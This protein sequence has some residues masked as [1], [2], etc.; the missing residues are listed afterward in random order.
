[1]NLPGTLS[2]HCNGISL[3]LASAF[4]L[5]RVCEGEIA[6]NWPISEFQYLPNCHSLATGNEVDTVQFH[7]KYNTA[8]FQLK[9]NLSVCGS[10]LA[11]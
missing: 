8:T 11:I 4:A 2:L 5:Q 3:E 9:P 1:M 10:Q 7:Q 6:K